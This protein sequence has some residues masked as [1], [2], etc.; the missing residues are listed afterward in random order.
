MLAGVTV[1]AS[2]M[3]CVDRNFCAGGMM[4]DVFHLHDATGKGPLSAFRLFAAIDQQQIG[5]GRAGWIVVVLGVHTDGTE[6]W[7]QVAPQH[8]PS[9]SIV[10]HMPKP[11]ATHHV[12]AALRAYD[13]TLE[14]HHVIEVSASI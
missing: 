3:Y 1:A 7:I 11:V 10:L 14:R 13:D 8:D 4:R 9:R 6:S 12:L 5:D 2:I